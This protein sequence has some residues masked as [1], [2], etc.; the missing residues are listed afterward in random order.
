M[1]TNSILTSGITLSSSKQLAQQ[2][3]EP[4]INNNHFFN[5]FANSFDDV[6]DHL[7]YNL[8]NKNTVT[9]FDLVTLASVINFLTIIQRKDYTENKNILNKL[10][11]IEELKTL[12]LLIGISKEQADSIVVGCK[13]TG[14]HETYHW[15]GLHSD[16]TNL[17]TGIAQKFY[18][19]IKELL[20]RDTKY[21]KLI[22]YGIISHKD[23]QKY[24]TGKSSIDNDTISNIKNFGAN[25][26]KNIFK[27][28]GASQDLYNSYNS[29]TNLISDFTN[30]QQLCILNSS[31]ILEFFRNFLKNNLKNKYL[32]LRNNFL[33][34]VDGNIAFDNLPPKA[35]K[36]L[37]PTKIDDTIKILPNGTIKQ[38]ILSDKN[39]HNQSV[40]CIKT[41]N[42]NELQELKSLDNVINVTAAK[43]IDEHII[44]VEGEIINTELY[45]KY[46]GTID[47]NGERCGKGTCA[48]SGNIANN[49]YDGYWQNNKMNGKGILIFSNGN[50]Y[51][52]MWED[53][54]IHGEGVLTRVDGSIIYKGDWINSK[55]HGVG[56]FIWTNGDRYEGDWKDDK[57]DGVGVFTRL[58]GYTY[59]GMWKNGKKH[60]QI[61]FIIV[62]DKINVEMQNDCIKNIANDNIENFMSLMA[63][64]RMPIDKKY[65]GPLITEQPISGILFF[66]I[67]L[68]NI[69]VSAEQHKS[70]NNAEQSFLKLLQTQFADV[71]NDVLSDEPLNNILSNCASDKLYMPN[72]YQHTMLMR[73]NN[74]INGNIA[75][76]V[77]NSGDGIYKHHYQLPNT[78][79]N[80]KYLLFQKYVFAQDQFK[81]FTARLNKKLT[82]EEFYSLFDELNAQRI[83]MSN[84]LGQDKIKQYCQ[85]AQKSGNCT[86]EA[87]TAYIRMALI[88]KFDIENGIALYNKLTMLML[89]KYILNANVLNFNQNYK[90][91]I[92]EKVNQRKFVFH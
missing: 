54:N 30:S 8:F 53:D 91:K 78:P 90:H 31:P 45:G 61:T 92:Q 19:K 5:K 29:S 7:I 18:D 4:P 6:S 9:S 2:N 37:A 41:I 57:Q 82:V 23:I 55:R 66:T 75:V 63:I 88:E 40:L 48:F 27:F 39:S 44:Y 81:K 51:E 70:F 21:A 72:I 20:K 89:E 87:C 86:I 65:T 67:F 17:H 22:N 36:L 60:G 12:M 68:S 34:N 79:K 43:W 38:L 13:H 56:I 47:E 42:L 77:I 50:K 1:G 71:H 11:S 32:D 74:Y 83:D 26:L 76:T 59:K 62:N 84:L 14:E 35:F 33:N 25:Y 46:T 64:H 16:E 28:K 85:A 73:M 58:D 3:L 15:W 80:N 52:G 10:P 49:N 24:Y 69:I